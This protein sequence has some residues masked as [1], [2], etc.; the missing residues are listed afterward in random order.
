MAIIKPGFKAGFRGRKQPATWNRRAHYLAS[1]HDREK[2]RLLSLEGHALTPEQAIEL[3]GGPEAPYHEVIVAPSEAECR[4]ILSRVPEDRDR[5][6]TEAGQRILKAYAEGKPAAFAVHEQDGR[7]HFHLAVKGPQPERALG[8][9]GTVQKLWTREIFGDE[10]RIMDWE[11]HQRFKAYKAELVALIAKQ[12]ANERGRIETLRGAPMVQ[13]AVLACPFE[14]RAR[15]FI[16]SRHRLE[17]A[18]LGARYE[19]RGMVGSP[20]HLAELEAVVHRRTGALRRLEKRELGRELDGGRGRTQRAVG[21][22]GGFARQAVDGALRDMGV[23]APIRVVA[24]TGLRMTQEVVQA[25]VKVAFE[26]A[27]PLAQESVRMGALA[28]EVAASAPTAGASRVATLAA[29]SVIEVGR[30][31]TSTATRK[32]PLPEPVKRAFEIAGYV[33]VAGTVAKAYRLAVELTYAAS[34]VRINEQEINR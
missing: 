15:D 12:R 32:A 8:K 30:A 5:A 31:V 22:A 21:L 11:A 4:T 1:E 34:S 19:A 14:Q 17:V 29:E 9:H 28:A 7:F 27:K 20:R 24:T 3:M 25:S 10:P 13:K 18:S 16:D 26:A 23:L 33:P 6:I 2:A